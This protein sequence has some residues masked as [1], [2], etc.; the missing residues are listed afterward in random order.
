MASKLNRRQI[1]ERMA[2]VSGGAISLS[3]LS[4]C[5][6]GVTVPVEVEN[7]DLKALNQKQLDLVGDIADTIIPNTDTP[8]AKAVNVHYLVDELAANWM[9]TIERDGF[10]KDLTALDDR[11]R[12]EHGKS[13]SNLDASGRGQV[14]DQLGVEMIASGQARVG[15]GD[16][17]NSDDNNGR[18]HIY[19]ELRELI[20]FGYYTSEVGASEELGFDPIPGAYHGCV[21][22][23]DVGKAWSV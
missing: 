22:F 4:A 20:I 6:G 18:K 23:A 13:F 1:L 19:L 7:I 14:L 16:I 5:D 2:M 21:P 10:L 8:G 3:I 9:T 17:T 11:I 15:L 12:N